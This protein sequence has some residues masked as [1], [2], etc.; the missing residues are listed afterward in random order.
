MAKARP[1]LGVTAQP[2]STFIQPNQNAVAAELY[3]QQTVQNALQ[4]AEAFSNLSV[5]AARLAGGLKQEWNEEQV[6]QGMDLVNKSRKS[7]QQLVQSG[8]IKPT[9]NPWFAVGAQK[10]SGSIEAMKARV[11]FESL[12]E[13]KVAEDPSFLD[14]PRGFDAFAYQYTQNVNQFMGDASYMSRAFYESFNP[15]MGTMQA[16]HEGRVIEHNTQ[17]ILTGVASEVQ[18][19][20][21]DWTSPNPTVS[22]QALGTLQTRLDEMVNQGV[23]SNRVNNA[24]VDALVELMATSDDPRA[25]REMFNSIKSGT[26]SLS[27]TQ[28]AKT[29]MAMNA[30]KIQANDLRMSA[31]ESKVLAAR[32][33]KDLTPQIVSGAITVEQAEEA[34]RE[35]FAQGKVRINANEQESKIG[36]LRSFSAAAIRERE[37]QVK[38]EQNNAFWELV[39]L[40]AD[41][42]GVEDLDTRL[43]E[44][45]QRVGAI[46]LDP[47]QLYRGREL[48]DRITEQAKKDRVL[49]TADAQTNELYQLALDAKNAQS[50]EEASAALKKYKDRIETLGLAPEQRFKA[51]EM[52]AKVQDDT[53]EAQSI[54]NINNATTI[55]WNGTGNGDG[56]LPTLDR[57]VRESFEPNSNF[58]PGFAE[59]RQQYDTYLTQTLGLT[60][61]NDTKYKKGLTQAYTKMRDALKQYETVYLQK[62][63]TRE[64]AASV[65]QRF[66][67]MRMNLATEFED[68]R[69]VA[70]A[71]R[72]L[73]SEMNPQVVERAGS[74]EVGALPYTEDM[75]MA[76]MLAN[77]NNQNLSTILPGGENGKALI[78]QLDYAVDR[79]RAGEKIGDVA[80]DVSRLMSFGGVSKIDYFDKINPVKW[81]DTD[82][83]DQQTRENIRVSYAELR[84]AVAA[85]SRSGAFEPDAGTY[86]DYEYRRHYATEVSNNPMAS[87][88]AHK[89]AMDKVIEENVL[90]R[91]SL[92]PKRNLGPNQDELYLEVWLRAKYPGNPNA[93]LVVVSPPGADQVLM[94]VRE[95]GKAVTSGLIRAQD[96]KMDDALFAQTVN[97]M[98]RG[99]NA[100]KLPPL[101]IKTRG[102]RSPLPAWLDAWLY[103]EKS[104]ILTR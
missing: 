79:I 26:G 62:A 82:G 65:R 92:L 2:V 8:E 31:E 6:Q 49:A 89:V 13:Q 16:K 42:D 36:Y 98:L 90:I 38:T 95:N 52:F 10:A 14:D 73:L 1:N 17:K 34:L 83:S 69:D 86:L 40:A 20:A 7:Y 93:T 91:G 72:G 60:D 68:A 21:Q 58:V 74:G 94:A 28:Y 11:N 18:R 56:I 50:D 29:Q 59:A 25:A 41:T 84:E 88:S 96:I 9:E 27:S 70:P 4:F 5:S 24:A 67:A 15:F 12:L 75:V 78:A 97:D 33:E 101:L 23:A 103:E 45:K 61:P 87:R 104:G 39:T 100:P 46:G 77:D 102:H 55:L 47:E 57:E 30:S 81:M 48:L 3:D 85:T 80:R 76:Y 99:K 53:F 71:F 51:E 64:E 35:D 44:L 66:L 19:A 37:V 43:G 63:A 54:R 22:Q 32:I